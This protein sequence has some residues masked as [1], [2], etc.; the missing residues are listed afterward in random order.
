M[1][2]QHDLTPGTPS[3]P[4]GPSHL[5]QALGEL[6]E[7]GDR[8]H[9]LH[10]ADDH[11]ALVEEMRGD[12]GFARAVCRADAITY[13]RRWFTGT[14]GWKTVEHR[15]GASGPGGV[16][17]EWTYRGVHDGAADFNSL[18]P[19][20]RPVSMRGMTMVG[21]E[22]GRM[23]MCRYVDWAGAFAQLGLTLNW[24][25]PVSSTPVVPPGGTDTAR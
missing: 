23:V 24:R 12:P 20:G 9:R 6:G 5:D 13:L 4:Q 17:I 22:K 16:A 7:H 18:A 21:L 1:S 2:D 19:T 14:D 25:V 8:F 10:R 11:S 3:G 15:S